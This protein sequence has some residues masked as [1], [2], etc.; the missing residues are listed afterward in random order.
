MPYPNEHSARL[1]DPGQFD[2]FARKNN[3]TGEGIDFIFGIKNGKSE[4]QAIRFNKK[5]FTVKEAKA[6]LKD[7]DI[8]YIDFE[9]AEDNAK[10]ALSLDQIRERI[11]SKVIPTPEPVELPNVYLIDVYIDY[12]II[13]R[14]GKYFKLPF[15]IDPSATSGDELKFGDEI[16]VE[17]DYVPVEKAEAARKAHEER[18]FASLRMTFPIHLRAAAGDRASEDYGY[19][20]D[21]RIVEYGPDKQDAIYWDPQVLRAAKPLYEGSKVFALTEAQHQAQ[22]HPFGKSIRDLVGWINNVT[23][24]DKGLGGDFNILKSAK[25][26]RD[27]AVDAFER[28]KPDLIGLSNDIGGKVAT[29]MVNGKRMRTP[30]E[31]SNVTIDI[32]YEPAAGGKFLRMAAAVEAG[33]K[34]AEMLKK[35]LAAMRAL[36]PDLCATVNEETVT[37]DQVIEIL[38]AAVT[39]I[40][41]PKEKIEF[42]TLL[43]GA[44]MA[45]CSITLKDELKDCGLP[46]L[47]QAK[48]R[49][50]FEGKVFE[51]DVL[52]A[53]IKEEKE[54]IDKLTGSGG[55]TGAGQI[56]VTKDE[57][58]KS[59]QMLDDIFEKKF[60]SIK[61]AYVRI[62]GDEQLSGRIDQA[63]R[64]RASLTQA[65]WAEVFG[66]SITR[67]ML[68]EY[69][70]AGLEDWR[71]IADV[72]PVSDVRT[73]R[74]VRIGGYG[75]LPTVAEGGAYTA[76]TSPTDE[77]ATYAV[78]KRGG[79]EDL[80]LEMIINDDVG[81]VRKIPQRLGRGAARTLYE[82]V[83][84]FIKD[85]PTIYD[86]VA[87]FHATHANLGTNALDATNLLASR[88]RMIKQ[89]ELTS[90]KRLGIL[91]KY[92]LVPPELAKTMWDLIS[93]PDTGQYTPTAPDFVK[94]WKIEMIEVIYWTDAN[95]WFLS[96]SP[97]DC[98]TIE[99]GFLNGNENPE[100]FVQDQPTVGSMFSNDKLT[101][102]IRH[103]YGGAVVDYR[104]L[105]GS[106]VA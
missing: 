58:D 64:L 37:E 87:L 20:W 80:T 106:I 53:A 34:E 69:A 67:R 3:E 78:P 33:R 28:G 74:R 39:K 77:E 13:S 19:K 47:S 68:K 18:S 52:R 6:W 27:M 100:L 4:I 12:A 59:K 8:K 46:D 65:T 97:A 51:A 91:P 36:R 42:Q 83:F 105:D 43:D 61:A 17:K 94:K 24:D 66:D 48:I 104:G 102:K 1:K 15:T 45:A 35:L 99:I 101:Y 21:V 92:G 38:K 88:N 9:K 63:P 14:D 75:N 5:K 10:A 22:A 72:V 95:N 32:V 85:N 31:I 89:T 93:T 2:S 62:T 30:V 82:F 76:L 49:K 71:K 29:K 50:Q 54:Y 25:W 11:Y 70:E 84:D 57:W 60:H 86:A 79:T 26:L 41:D 40:Q 44:K 55:I 90:G 98:P 16:E 7:K 103:R 73:Q 81:G 23:D 96:A 56:Q